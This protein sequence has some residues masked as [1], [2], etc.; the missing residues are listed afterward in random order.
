M[1]SERMANFKVVFR[2]SISKDLQRIPMR[3][4]ARILSRIEA[5]ASEPRPRGVEKLSGQQRYRIRQGAY[6]ILYEVRDVESLVVVVKIG[7]RRDV[8][9]SG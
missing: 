1:T 2:Q 5:L 3:D 8:Y 7:H 4:I 6:R 9:R